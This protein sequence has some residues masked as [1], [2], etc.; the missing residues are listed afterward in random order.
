MTTTRRT[1]RLF[2]FFF[3]VS[4]PVV[5]LADEAVRVRG[6]ALARAR[7]GLRAGLVRGRRSRTDMRWRA[8]AF[9]VRARE[10]FG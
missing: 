5:A 6:D 9:A 1:G 4:V 10:R 7:G 3:F 2:F 8:R